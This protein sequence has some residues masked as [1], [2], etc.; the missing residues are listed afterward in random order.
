[1]DVNGGLPVECQRECKS[2]T[3]GQLPVLVSEPQSPLQIFADGNHEIDAALVT[4]ARRAM[5]KRAAFVVGVGS[6]VPVTDLDRTVGPRTLDVEDPA[7]KHNVAT[8]AL[9]VCLIPGHPQ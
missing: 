5:R 7:T 9:I 1:M 6:A 4:G 8:I 3:S 2:F